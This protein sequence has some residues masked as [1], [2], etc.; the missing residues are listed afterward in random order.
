MFLRLSHS[1]EIKLSSWQWTLLLTSHQ[2][3]SYS[4]PTSFT[5]LSWLGKLQ[6]LPKA[7]TPWVIL[8]KIKFLWLFLT[9]LVQNYL[10]VW[11]ICFTVAWSRNVSQVYGM[12]QLN[13]LYTRILVSV[14]SHHNIT[15][16]G[17]LVLTANFLSVSWTRKIVDQFNR[18]NLLSDK[19]Y[20]YCSFRSTAYIWTIIT[21]KTCQALDNKLLT[22]EIVLDL[23]RCCIGGGDTNSPVMASLDVSSQLSNPSYQMKVVVNGPSS[24]AHAIKDS[25][26]SYFLF[27]FILRTCLTTFSAHL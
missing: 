13:V 27:F 16:S 6:D 18:K 2:T 3:T 21:H 8:V 26:Q 25:V 7:F 22:R 17:S 4:L 14:H 12:Y 11:Q 10:Q 20:N 24:E 19:E 15:P 1:C 5:I 23:T 9:A